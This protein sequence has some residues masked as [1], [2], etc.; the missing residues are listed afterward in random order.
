MV[1]DIHMYESDGRMEGRT[2]ARLDARTDAQTEPDLMSLS[3]FV[4][5]G[6]NIKQQTKF[7]DRDFAMVVV[8]IGCQLLVIHVML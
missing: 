4:R 6:T 1:V 5:R 8:S 7:R 3:N 2:D